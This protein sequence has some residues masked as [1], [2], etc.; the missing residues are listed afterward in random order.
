MSVRAKA[1]G[2]GLLLVCLYSLLAIASLQ[3]ENFSATIVLD[4]SGDL[5]VTETL[6]TRFFTPHHGIERFIQVSG[7]AA[8][9]ERIKITLDVLEILL[10]DK[11]VPYTRRA[12][13]TD[14]IFRIGDPDRTIVGL[15]EYTISYR[16]GRAILFSDDAIHLYWNVT[17]HGWDVPIGQASAKVRLPESVSPDAVS[18]VAYI[19]YSGSAARQ[20][21]GYA[22]KDGAITFTSGTLLPRE[23]MT[24]LLSIP[25]DMLPIDPPTLWLRAAWFVDANKY[26]ALPVVT[27]LV[28][29]VLWSKLGKD[30]RKRVIAPAFA[31]PRDIH[32]GSAGV[33]I[34]DRIDLRDISA[35]LVGLAVKGHIRIQEEEGGGYVFVRLPGLVTALSPAEQAVFSALFPSADVTERTMASLEQDFYKSLPTIKS[36]L[37]DELIHAGYYKGNPERTRRAYVAVA[38]MALPLAAWVALQLMLYLAVSILLSGAVVLA[39]SRIMPRKTVPGVRKLEEILGLSEY[40]RRAEVDRIEFHNAPE[41]S[42]QLFEALLPYAIALNLTT[43]WTRQFEGLLKDAPSWYVGSGP[44]PLFNAH[45]FSSTLSTMTR[46]MHQTFV[47][48]PRSSGQSAW[49]GRGTSGGGFSGGGFSGG[50]FGGGGG[51]G[52]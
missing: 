4:P 48:A 37:Y 17:G 10:D 11:P 35:M 36:R 13:G 38:L 15:H 21:P 32:P 41:K 52:W 44:T 18:S 31:P 2:S 51:R 24:V 34:D 45:M 46:T 12:S 43:V 39:F 3:I 40:I 25:R 14:R 28:M 8:W 29:L 5:L 22:A 6:M 16:V 9:G 50:G 27:L 47:S 20:D 23:G 19:G 1:F 26:A 42:P 33:L 49:G 30:P 7:Q